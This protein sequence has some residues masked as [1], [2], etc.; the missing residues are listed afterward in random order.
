MQL[1]A[2]LQAFSHWLSL[3]GLSCAE[4]PERLA[5]FQGL[6]TQIVTLIIEMLESG[7]GFSAHILFTELRKP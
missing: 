4:K 7:V 1:F 2:T 6:L 5:D 3:F